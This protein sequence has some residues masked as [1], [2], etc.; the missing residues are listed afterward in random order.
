[1]LAI[2]LDFRVPADRQVITWMIPVVVLG[3]PIFDMVLVVFTRLFEGRSPMMGGKDHTSH[4]LT[5]IGLSQR[6]AVLVLYGVCAALGLTAI[7]L[8]HATIE[9]GLAI[10]VV[11]AVVAVIAFAFLTW[12]YQRNRRAS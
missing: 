6:A 11:L 5:M 12:A 9:E 3:L 1:V 4:R 7:E 10:G 2:K 8:S